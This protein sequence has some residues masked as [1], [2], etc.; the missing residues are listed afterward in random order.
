MRRRFLCGLLFASLL[1]VVACDSNDGPMEKAGEAADD[2][3]DDV[4]D[5]GKDIKDA[6]DK[7]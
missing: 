1:G 6:V 5:A 3:V 4:K 7:D 2:V